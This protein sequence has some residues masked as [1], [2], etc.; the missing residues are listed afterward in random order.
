MAYYE[1]ETLSQRIRRGPLPVN[2]A[3]N[4]AI[5]MAQGLAEAHAHSV[6]HRDIKPSNVI[7]TSQGVAKIVD[8]GLARVVKSATL[9]Q[10]GGITG[11]IA[12]MSPEQ[13]VGKRVDQRTDIWSLGVVLAE[14]LTGQNPFQR[15][16]LPSIMLAIMGQPPGLI[17]GV[18]PELQPIIYRALSKDPESL[19]QNCAE[20]LAD[21]QQIRLEGG[22]PAGVDD[23][24][25]T[26]SVRPEEFRKYV[27]KASGSVWRLLG[28]LSRSRSK[29]KN[30]SSCADFSCAE[31]KCLYSACANSNSF[32]MRG[33]ERARV[34]RGGSERN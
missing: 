26:R 30:L 11:T 16:T 33:S 18:P 29:P 14:M 1:G 8:F 3:V 34:A 12:Y 21:L 15:D 24:S 28:A 6:V 7:L 31:N 9:T 23:S 4:I 32:R 19:Y 22:A 20:L 10:S 25:P 13:A 27:E 5:Q 17:D 2:Q